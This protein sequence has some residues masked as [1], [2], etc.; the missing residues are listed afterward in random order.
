ML[1][2]D[3]HLATGAVPRP[4]HSDCRSNGHRHARARSRVPQSRNCYELFVLSCVYE[5]PDCFRLFQP[6]GRSL[7]GCVAAQKPFTVDQA[8]PVLPQ[9]GRLLLV[10]V[11]ADELRKSSSPRAGSTR[12]VWL[13]RRAA[14]PGDSGGCWADWVRRHRHTEGTR[15]P[16]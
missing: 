11:V 13:G 5:K 10:L 3:S 14:K 15:A 6:E 16:R 7:A 8:A 4:V 1:V 9:A 12:A 2:Y